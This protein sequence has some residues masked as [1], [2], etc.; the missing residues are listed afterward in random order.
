MTIRNGFFHN[1]Q[2]VQINIEELG[3]LPP[4]KSGSKYLAKI[5]EDI[6][7]T[8][9]NSE[10]D[11]VIDTLNSEIKIPLNE[12]NSSL[13]SQFYRIDEIILFTA[14]NY[15]FD[16]FKKKIKSDILEK[17]YL[18]SIINDVLTIKCEQ[19]LLKKA[20]DNNYTITIQFLGIEFYKCNF[21]A[22]FKIEKIM[23]DNIETISKIDFISYIEKRTESSKLEIINDL[24]DSAEDNEVEQNEVLDNT[25]D[26][27]EDKVSQ[28]INT[29]EKPNDI[30]TLNE[31]TND[32]QTIENDS[33]YNVDNI[34]NINNDKK[35]EVIDLFDKAESAS[36]NADILRLEAIKS[37]TELRETVN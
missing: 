34:Q 1:N 36:K 28:E 11:I 9:N 18:P 14:N 12:K 10:N 30:V 19:E 27:R 7:I 24:I 23:S 6:F 15:C 35:Q 13:L 4:D 16:W 8:I 25:S 32:V 33:I 5:N 22:N 17:L 20:I 37:A 2:D 26:N 31:V 29:Q 21:I 3:F